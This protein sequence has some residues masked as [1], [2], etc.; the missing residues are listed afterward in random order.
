MLGSNIYVVLILLTQLEAMIPTMK[1]ENLNC[2]LNIRTLNCRSIASE[3][4]KQSIDIDML[5]YNLDV[6]CLQE[7]KIKQGSIVSFENCKLLLMDFTNVH[8]EIGFAIANKVKV[9]KSVY[10]SDRICDAICSK[11]NLKF[12]VINVYGPTQV[13]C[14]KYPTQSEEFLDLLQNT[15]DSLHGL[16]VIAGGFNSKIGKKLHK[17]GKISANDNGER[18]NTFMKANNLK[19]TNTMFKHST[20]HVTTWTGKIKQKIIHNTIDFIL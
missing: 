6:C 12:N 2:N 3:L 20:K 16:T 10:I 14:T 8:Y 7:T 1:A 9:E 4:K 15:Y 19:P 11:N 18:L 17:H 5:D 13:I